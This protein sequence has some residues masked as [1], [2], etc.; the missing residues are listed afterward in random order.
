MKGHASWVKNIEYAHNAELLVT[1]GFDGSIYAWD[2][3]RCVTGLD[4]L[5]T[6]YIL[7]KMKGHLE[8]NRFIFCLFFSLLNFIR[9]LWCR[10]VSNV[11]KLVVLLQIR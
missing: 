10:R 8:Y 11:M 6:V 4:V 3:N 7:I 2:I 1:S 5:Q 9:N